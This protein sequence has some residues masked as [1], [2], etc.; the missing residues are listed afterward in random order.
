RALPGSPTKEA[1]MPKAAVTRAAVAAGLLGVLIAVQADLLGL[2]PAVARPIVRT[3]L[4]AAEAAL[5]VAAIRSL[6]AAAFSEVRGQAILVWRNLTAWTL[7]A[8]LALEV[9]AGFGINLSGLL[10]GGAIVGVVLA[11]VSQASLGNFF[12]GLVLMLAR[13]FCV[14]D[15]V[16]LRTSLVGGVEFEGTVV[17]SRALYTT[18]LTAD[19]ELL[20]IPNSA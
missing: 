9:A 10:V 19:G 8:L 5:G 7:Y 12:A 20:R 16:R 11:S 4:L 3:L 1:S 13:P 2:S 14:G 18:L 15:T 6:L 17:D